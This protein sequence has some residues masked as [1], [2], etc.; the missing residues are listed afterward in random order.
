MICRTRRVDEVADRT[1]KPGSYRAAVL[2]HP[3]AAGFSL[4]IAGRVEDDRRSAG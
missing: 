4:S 2:V 3:E 1:E